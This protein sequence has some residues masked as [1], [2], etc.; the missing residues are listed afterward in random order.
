MLHSPALMDLF[1]ELTNSR[2]D[3]D[4]NSFTFGGFRLATEATG[5]LANVHADQAADWAGLVYLTPDAPDSA[6]TGFF[7]TVRL[8][9][10]G[11]PPTRRPGQTDTEMPSPTSR[12]RSF[13]T[14]RTPPPGSSW[15]G[16]R[17][18]TTG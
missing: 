8:G 1:G 3:V 17:R 9:W 16:S 12:Q 13:P 15:S 6:G 5:R 7:G 11:H 10:N 14:T 2:V 18:P 4:F